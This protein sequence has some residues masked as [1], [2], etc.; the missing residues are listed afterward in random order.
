MGNVALK[1]E[2]TDDADKYAVSGRGLLHLTVLIETM[3][4]EGFEMMVGCPQVIEQEIDG[5]RMEPFEMVDID[6]PEEYSGSVI[7]LLNNRKGNMLD[8]GAPSDQGMVGLQ[9]E[10]PSRGMNGVKSALLSITRGLMIMTSTFAGYKP[11]AGDFA[12]RTSG[13]LFSVE[14]GTVTSYSIASA[15][16]RGVLFCK[17]GD[18]IYENQIIG[19]SSRDKDLGLNVC[20]TKALTN[21]R[22]AGSDEVTKLVPPKVLTLEDAVEYIVDGEYVEVTPDAIRIGMHPKLNKNKR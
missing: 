1:V 5:E 11:Y 16:A 21:T 22:A 3:R 2:Q 7:S 4:R 10:M 20:K 19:I 6:V 18:E 15:Q 13:N 12:G 17:A 9:Y 8:M 14:T